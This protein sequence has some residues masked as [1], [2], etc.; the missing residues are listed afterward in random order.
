M[1]RSEATALL[2]C[3]EC[4]QLH[5][6]PRNRYQR[7]PRNMCMTLL[8]VILTK[9]A[10]FRNYGTFCLPL[11]CAYP[12][13]KYAYICTCLVHVH[14]HPLNMECGVISGFITPAS[15]KIL[16]LPCLS[17]LIRRFT[18]HNLCDMNPTSWAA[19]VA[20]LVELLP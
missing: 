19:S 6:S 11:S 12:Q 20:Q 4:H 13:Y 8:F 2:A 17:G 10:S 3:L 5:L 1:L 14:A 16:S 7:N 15:S 9:T 18:L